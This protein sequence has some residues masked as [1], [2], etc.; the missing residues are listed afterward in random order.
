MPSDQGDPARARARQIGR[1]I[2]GTFYF[3]AGILHLA[4]PGPFLTITPD[5]VPYPGATVALTGVAEIAGA[6]GLWTQRWRRAAA[7]GLAL[8]ALAVWPANF[9][10]MLIDDGANLLYHATRLP[11]QIPL[12]WWTLWSGGVTDW[13]W[14][15]H[16][17]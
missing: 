6:T 16:A 4:A 1:A 8:Y 13:P 14:R 5:W 10:H 11:L 15:R 2:I 9:N 3:V 12:I 7:I 17:A